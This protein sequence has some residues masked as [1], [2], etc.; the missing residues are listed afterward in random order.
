MEESGPQPR[1]L[2]VAFRLPEKTFNPLT[3]GWIFDPLVYDSQQNRELS[4]FLD[5]RFQGEMRMEMVPLLFKGRPADLVSRIREE[6]DLTDIR[7]VYGA[8]EV[9]AP[10]NV[11]RPLLEG[12]KA[13]PL[14]YL[15][16]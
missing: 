11:P 7:N 15:S 4:T 12:L 8:T 5:S 9:R 10:L 2:Y 6:Y 1:A 16:P 13:N 3:T 14:K